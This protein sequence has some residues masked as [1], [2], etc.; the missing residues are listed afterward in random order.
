[1]TKAKLIRVADALHMELLSQ[2]EALM[3]ARSGKRAADLDRISR[4]VCDYED[5]R[6]PIKT[7]RR[8]AR[9]A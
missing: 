5:V 6:W 7:I 8:H 9:A 1:M 3:N 4:I 2:C